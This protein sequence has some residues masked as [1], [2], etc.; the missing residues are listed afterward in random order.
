MHLSIWFVH[1][2]ATSGRRDGCEKLVSMLRSARGAPFESVVARYVTE[3]DADTLSMP[4][5]Q[6]NV[7]LEKT[8]DP[9]LDQLLRPLS[10]RHVSNFE[11]HRLALEEI[12]R[13]GPAGGPCLVLEDDAVYG[14]DVAAALSTALAATSDAP[15]AFLGLPYA[16]KAEPAVEVESLANVF[17]VL[18]SCDAYTVTPAAAARLLPHMRPVRFATNVHLT[19]AINKAGLDAVVAVPN[20][21]MDGSKLG[22]HLGTI[23]VN[24][25]LIYNPEYHRLKALVAADSDEVAEFARGM[26]FQT[27]PEIQLVLGMHDVRKGRYAD[28]KRRF[29]SAYA[30][31]SGGRSVMNGTSLLLQSYIDVFKHL[32]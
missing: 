30:V 10:L 1:S 23:D 6:K 29:E 9:N 12:S 4:D 13:R 22:S 26:K 27:N 32:Q 20:V 19:Y 28:A 11:K 15:V 7:S 3:H 25:P 21:F 24:N 2:A 18:P 14:A 8:G 5:V 31:H 16:R 17:N